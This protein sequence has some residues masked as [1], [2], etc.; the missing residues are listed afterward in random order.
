M[1]I[2]MIRL[3][4]Q[5][6]VQQSGVES[7]GADLIP[8]RKRRDLRFPTQRGF[9]GADRTAASVERRILKLDHNK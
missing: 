5:L 7:D 8:S 2:L 9:A 4:I 6:T 1:S 3:L